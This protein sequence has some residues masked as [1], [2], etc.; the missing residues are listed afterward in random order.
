MARLAARVASLES[1]FLG[2]HTRYV[3]GRGEVAGGR[4]NG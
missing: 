2:Q 3:K 1:G 4:S